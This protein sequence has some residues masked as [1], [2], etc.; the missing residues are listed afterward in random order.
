SWFARQGMDLQGSLLDHQQNGID[1]TEAMTHIVQMQLE[2]L[3]P[4]ILD[5]FRQTMKMEDL[6]ARGDAR[7]AMA[8]KFNL[9]A[10]FGDAQ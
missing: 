1:G 8:E 6:S 4:Q 2:K 10:M 3:N 5:T 9:G 7:Q